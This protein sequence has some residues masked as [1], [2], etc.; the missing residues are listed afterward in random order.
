MVASKLWFEVLKT[1]EAN[2][3]FTTFKG[4]TILKAS[5]L[6]GAEGVSIVTNAFMQVGL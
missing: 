1:M 3:N 5:E 2:D 4:R 6:H